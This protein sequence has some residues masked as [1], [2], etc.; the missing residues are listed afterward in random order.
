M[1]GRNS[2]QVPIW[3]V[4]RTGSRE[5]PTLPRRLLIAQSSLKKRVRGA[6]AV[7]QS[8]SQRASGNV[9]TA[10]RHRSGATRAPVIFARDPD[11]ETREPAHLPSHVN[12]VVAMLGGD[13]E[14]DLAFALA[15]SISLRATSRAMSSASPHHPA[16][17]T[18]RLV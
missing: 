18:L 7:V 17:S 16:L 5:R 1:R 15:A 14:R 8:G 9:A 13:R 6:P 3:E 4:D 12:G 11:N 10:V 2:S